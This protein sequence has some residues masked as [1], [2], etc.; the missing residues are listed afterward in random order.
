M[1][2]TTHKNAPFVLNIAILSQTQKIE[3]DDAERYE[4]W[5]QSMFYNDKATPFEHHEYSVIEMVG[6]I[7]IDVEDE[8]QYY[9]LRK[10]VEDWQEGDY[11][12]IYE[13]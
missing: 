8:P 7:E 3:M 5:R 4:R 9:E 11:F 10:A 13:F 6:T 2:M 12:R 1:S